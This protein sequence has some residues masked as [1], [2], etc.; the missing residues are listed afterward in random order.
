VTKKSLFGAG[1]LGVF[2]GFWGLLG[3]G[4]QKLARE[5]ANFLP[6]KGKK[7]RIFTCGAGVSSRSRGFCFAKWISFSG[8][9]AQ[10]LKSWLVERANFC[11]GKAKVAIGLVWESSRSRGLALKG[12]WIGFSGLKAGRLDF[13][14]R[15]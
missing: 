3:S 5:R 14:D 9:S 13:L 1:L 4:S 10:G 12:Q 7:L 8:P 15:F 11:P 6:F 2:G